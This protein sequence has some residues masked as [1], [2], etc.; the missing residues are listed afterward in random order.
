MCR[1]K[2]QGAAAAVRGK[3]ER[4]ESRIHGSWSE[5]AWDGTGDVFVFPRFATLGRAETLYTVGGY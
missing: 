1:W 2:T 3:R 5:R 4:E